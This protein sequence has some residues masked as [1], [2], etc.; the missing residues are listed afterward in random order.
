[1]SSTIIENIYAH[2]DDEGRSYSILKAITNHKASDDAITKHQGFYFTPS[3][4]KCRVITTKGWK[5]MVEWQDG[6]SSWIALK[7]IKDAK[8]L[9]V[10]DYASR[11]GLLDEPAFAWWAA[12]VLK[13]RTRLINQV[14]HR[15]VKKDLKFGVRVPNSME[16]ALQFDKDN[17]NDLWA[18]SIEKE[19]KNVRVAFELLREGGRFL[20]VPNL[21]LII[22]YLT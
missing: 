5:L 22:L 12:H 7:D 14:K 21:S 17:G 1:M 20:S 18:K 4:V 11:T 13:K 19:L 8:P 16:E 9:E 3:G 6:T 2:V 10:A 15:M